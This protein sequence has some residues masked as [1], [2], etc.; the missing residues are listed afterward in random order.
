VVAEY[1]V[2][3]LGAGLAGLAAARTC[4]EDGL[5]VC[6]LEARD[7]VGGRTWTRRFLGGHV[8]LGAEWVSPHRHA[9]VMAELTRYGIELVPTSAQEQVS[10]SFEDRAQASATIL[11]EDEEHELHAFYAAMEEDASRIDF[12]DPRWHETVQDLDISMADYLARFDLSPVT[13]GY[14]LLHAFSLMGADEAVYSALHLL[15]ELA[16]FGT[17]TEAF[18]GESDRILGGTMSIAAAIAAEMDPAQIRFGTAATAVREHADGTVEVA[19]DQG[20]FVGA[21]AIV[22]VPVNVLAH[23]ELGV[24]L[25]DATQR[26]LTEGHAGSIT[27]VWTAAENLPTPYASAGWPDVPESYGIEA[28]G[29][30]A[31][32]AFQLVHDV[33]S[34]GAAKAAITTLRHR[35][36]QASFADDWL[37]HDWV[38]DPW[39]R[40]TWHTARVGQATGWYDLA[41]Q[42]GPVFFAGGDLSRRWVGWMDGALTSGLDAGHRAVALIA[43]SDVPPVRG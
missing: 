17:C 19:T 35:H 42:P 20:S 23:L 13:R 9:A 32:A 39:S 34:A 27:K 43:G 37:T 26:V 10:W 22:A 2:V 21:A 16:G 1:D 15:H 29:G 14:V 18:D 7:R 38:N 40:G 8:D 25:S 28:P 4:V 31:V 36:P 11:T 6:V 41:A 33:D 24:A 30:L 5:R 3:V 12:A